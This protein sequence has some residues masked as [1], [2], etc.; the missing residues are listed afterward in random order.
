MRRSD[1]ELLALDRILSLLRS[2]STKCSLSSDGQKWAVQGPQ[3]PLRMLGKCRHAAT[4]GLERHQGSMSRCLESRMFFCGTCTGCSCTA[5]VQAAPDMAGR[6]LRLSAEPSC[7]V[8]GLLQRCETSTHQG[9]RASVCSI[10][11]AHTD[12]AILRRGDM[13]LHALTDEA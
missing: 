2:K 7:S 3:G 6:D 8:H 10:R 9:F 5:F 12:R 13:Q 4:C 11:K 1:Q